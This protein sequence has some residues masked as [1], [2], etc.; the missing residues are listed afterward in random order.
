MKNLLY[1]S[2]KR[3]S[4]KNPVDQVPAPSV[5]SEFVQEVRSTGFFLHEIYN[6]HCCA[7]EEKLEK[8]EPD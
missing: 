4:N 5:T 7:S 6:W 2:N 8:L 3:F 1:K